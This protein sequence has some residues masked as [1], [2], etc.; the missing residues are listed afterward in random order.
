MNGLERVSHAYRATG[1]RD[2]HVE[3]FDPGGLAEPGGT[4]H[5]ALQGRDKLRPRGVVFHLVRLSLGVGENLT[6]RVDDGDPSPS[7]GGGLAGELIQRCR[8][9]VRDARSKHLR[10]LSQ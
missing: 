9:G 4:P 10:L 7:G 6:A 1:N 3:Q 8:R 5:L 2:R